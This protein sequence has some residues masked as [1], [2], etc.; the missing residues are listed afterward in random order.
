MN[1]INTM[2]IENGI[3]YLFDKYL[4]SNDN[5]L[6]LKAYLQ[7]IESSDENLDGFTILTNPKQSATS[8]QAQQLANPTSTLNIIKK[9][10]PTHNE[11]DPPSNTILLAQKLY[12]V[13]ITVDYSP[14][15]S[16]LEFIKRGLEVIFDKFTREFDDFYENCANTEPHI[17][18][19][20]LL[21]NSSPSTF[22]NNTPTHKKDSTLPFIMLLHSKR[23][24]KSN[25]SEMALFIFNNISQ[26]K[27]VIID[28]VKVITDKELRVNTNTCEEES[29]NICHP[30]SQQRHGHQKSK[31]SFE[32]FLR[33][34]VKTFGFFCVNEVTSSAPSSAS[35]PTALASSHHI[36]LT[37]G[38][39]HATDIIKCLEKISKSSITFSFIYSGTSNHLT[40]SNIASSFGHLA[41][42]SLMKLIAFITN[43]FYAYLDDNLELTQLISR[44]FLYFY[45]IG[46]SI[47]SLGSNGS[48][49]S[50]RIDSLDELAKISQ[51]AVDDEENRDSFCQK[52][53]SV[54]N[55]TK[56]NQTTRKPV[57]KKQKADKSEP[58]DIKSLF[59]SDFLINDQQSEL[60]LIQKYELAQKHQ[61]L[62]Q[63]SRIRAQEGFFISNI[64]RRF[65]NSK[66]SNSKSISSPSRS[67][68]KPNFYLITLYFKKYFTQTIT[69][70]YKISYFVQCSDQAKLTDLTENECNSVSEANSNPNK[71][72]THN[73]QKLY[74]ELWISWNLLHLKAKYQ[75][76]EL[77]KRVKQFLIHLQSSDAN[78]T[79][80]LT[81]SM[82]DPPEILKL[83]EPL[84]KLSTISNES[85]N[86]FNE[87]LVSFQIDP[88]FVSHHQKPIISLLNLNFKLNI[89]TNKNAEK[90]LFNDFARAW[91]NLEFF[92]FN[93][94]SLNKFF[95]IHSIKLLIDYD[96]P[97]PDT[98][99]CIF[100]TKSRMALAHL[101]MVQNDPN[102]NPN[103]DAQNRHNH[104]MQGLV[105]PVGSIFQCQHSVNKM[106]AMLTDWCDL[107]LIENC[108]YLKYLESSSKYLKISNSKSK[109]LDQVEIKDTNELE[110]CD[111]SNETQADQSQPV[112]QNTSTASSSGPNLTSLNTSFVILITNEQYT[113]YVSLQFLFHSNI[114]YLDRV[115]L[116][117]KFREK[118]RELNPTNLQQQVSTTTP[119]QKTSDTS[120]NQPFPCTSQLSSKATNLSI[121]ETQRPRYPI[122]NDYCHLL[123]KPDLY[124]A[125]KFILFDELNNQNENQ[126][127]NT[128]LNQSSKLVNFMQQKNSNGF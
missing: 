47:S 85:V 110:S 95:G 76:L 116:L 115:R 119:T 84:Y 78:S 64:T 11:S 37:D 62:L 121:E 89:R 48:R 4:K 70:V 82:L 73:N 88:E 38:L 91:Q 112:D 92:R 107:M 101:D 5:Y 61:S 31:S 58:N 25:L 117:E 102:S 122:S 63:I 108:V 67:N 105:S 15:T 41:D 29:I 50:S 55:L 9:P 6:P 40:G 1:Q 69:L 104:H 27:F 106:R 93:K 22:H 28:S 13:I 19:T 7:F 81:P 54:R 51:E 98:N 33:I 3:Y 123:H 56:F 113:P 59:Y 80:D 21:W 87:N 120:L 14:Q 36:H 79:F 100:D 128:K 12:K 83:K 20:V 99:T 17:Y 68:N 125:F 8:T 52:S 26:S 18:V 72:Q 96:R 94:N 77:I 2:K 109:S 43:G 35:S 16:S 34:I 32:E 74:V 124:D 39:I 53:S 49:S 42:Y 90:D 71:N 57:Y 45:R 103:M 97:L 66:S 86:S 10:C 24:L 23:L 111:Q 126:I 127:Q 118:L 60:K 44:R 65:I 30:Q 46:S 114:S 75:N